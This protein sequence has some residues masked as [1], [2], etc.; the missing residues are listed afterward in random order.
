MKPVEV[1]ATLTAFG[2]PPTKVSATVAYRDPGERA[3]RALG[4]LGLFWSLALFGVFIPVAHLIL[5]P[6][7]LCAGVIVGVRRAREDRTLVKV[8]GVCPRCG[9]EHDFQVGGRVA[10][11]RTL[12]CPDCHNNLLLMLDER[13]DDR[14]TAS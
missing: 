14:L 11:E 9:A 3:L 10:R 12:A 6:S 5:V 4:G 7:L 13:V 8:C 1:P 2:A